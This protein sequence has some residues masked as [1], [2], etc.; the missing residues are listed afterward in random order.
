LFATAWF[1]ALP[2]PFIG[3]QKHISSQPAQRPGDRSRPGEVENIR[4][5][6]E[7]SKSGANYTGIALTMN[8]ENRPTRT[9]GSK[10]YPSTIVKILRNNRTQAA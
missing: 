10:W 6:V 9:K 4:R 3:T 7:L 8:A 1:V 2:A 5:I